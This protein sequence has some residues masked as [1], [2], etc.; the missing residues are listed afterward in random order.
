M[1]TKK[2]LWTRIVVMTGDANSSG[3]EASGDHDDLH[4]VPALLGIVNIYLVA[5]QFALNEVP[6]LRSLTIGAQA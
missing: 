5:N 3:G 4:M 6:N 2:A 1:T